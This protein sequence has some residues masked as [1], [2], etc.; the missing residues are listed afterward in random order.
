MACSAFTFSATPSA[1]L[2]AGHRPVLVGMDEDQTRARAVSSSPTTPSSSP[3]SD[4]E[5]PHFAWR[6]DEIRAAL[7]H[8]MV[9]ALPDRLARHRENYDAIT[10]ELALLDGLRLRRPVAPGAYTGQF[11]TLRVTGAAAADADWYANA[12]RA[13]GIAA[14]ALGSSRR[15]NARA[16]WNWAYLL[17]ADPATAR[18]HLPHSARRLGEAVDI[19]LSAHLTPADRDDLVDAIGK[20][21][22]A[23][24]VRGRRRGAGVS[25]ALGHTPS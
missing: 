2:L 4:R 7:A 13:E 11:L 20:V 10:D 16:F 9:R 19:P 22:T 8:S 25:T 23:W 14:T 18:A 15:P 24:T 21:H 5:F 3:V 6:M 17:G 1:I 12:L